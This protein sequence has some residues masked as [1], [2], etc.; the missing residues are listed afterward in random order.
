MNQ[1]LGAVLGLVLFL[2]ALALGGATGYALF[3]LVHGTRWPTI[4]GRYA[5]A[6]IATIAGLFVF[7]GVYWA[8][9]LTTVLSR[10]GSPTTIEE[11]GIWALVMGPI[12]A[13]F[14]VLRY[15]R[16]GRRLT[17]PIRWRRGA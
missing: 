11:I 7:F 16:L 12:Y 1:I 5:A 17:R 15:T 3:R 8:V 13:A 6:A 14:I 4:A 10:D 2:P 9:G